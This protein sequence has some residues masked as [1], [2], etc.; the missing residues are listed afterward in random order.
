VSG[1]AII[2]P[3]AIALDGNDHIWVSKF[4]YALPAIVELCGYR[5]DTCPSGMR[6]DDSISPPGGY[7]GGG[8]QM[9]VDIAIDQAGDVWV[10]NNWQDRQAGLEEVPEARSSLAAGQGLVV[11]YDMAKSVRPPL[12]GLARPLD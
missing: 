2:V 5:T 11:F 8:L 1:N 7:V 12:I 6:M 3:W 4:T 9:Q 10:S